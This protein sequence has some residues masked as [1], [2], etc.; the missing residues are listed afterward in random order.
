MLIECDYCGIFFNKKPSLMKLSSKHYCTQDCHYTAKVKK[1]IVIC[2]YCDKPV[3]KKRSDAARV[4][5]HYCNRECAQLHRVGENHPSWKGEY[6]KDRRENVS[7]KKWKLNILKRDDFTCSKCGGRGGTLNVHHIL[8]YS[9]YPEAR[10]SMDNGATLCVSC[11]KDFHRLY[12][13]LKFTD[14]DYFEWLQNNSS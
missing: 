3:I 4:K 10:E 6:C 8:A 5:H 7:Y 9:R 13:S 12:G 11:H 2:E 1:V 14:E